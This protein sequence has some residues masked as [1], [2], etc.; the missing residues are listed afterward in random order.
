MPDKVV[1]LIVYR[2]E[3]I[4]NVC[5]QLGG[6]IADEL[7]LCSGDIERNGQNVCRQSTRRRLGYAIRGI[8]IWALENGIIYTTK[9][10]IHPIH[11]AYTRQMKGLTLLTRMLQ[12]QANKLDQPVPH[13]LTLLHPQNATNTPSKLVTKLG[14]IILLIQLVFPTRTRTAVRLITAKLLHLP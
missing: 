9:S 2:V 4:D 14:L 8:D 7:V 12:K 11:R 10:A 1:E 6:S 3:G 5:D 13:R